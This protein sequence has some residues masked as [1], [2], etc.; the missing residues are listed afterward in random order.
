[1]TEKRYLWN[2]LHPCGGD[3]ILLITDRDLELQLQL[4]KDNQSKRN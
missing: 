3:Q 4:S 1:M 2:D